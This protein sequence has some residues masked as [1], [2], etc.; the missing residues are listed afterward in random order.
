MFTS[1]NHS[2]HEKRRC[3]LSA[4]VSTVFFHIWGWVKTLVPSEP[5]VIAGLKWMFI[6]L[7]YGIYIGIDPYPFFPSPVVAC[8]VAYVVKNLQGLEPALLTGHE[9]CIGARDAG[10]KAQLLRLKFDSVGW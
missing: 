3:S 6:P 10:G 5:Q 8:V 7:K 9:P 2:N 1:I 4:R